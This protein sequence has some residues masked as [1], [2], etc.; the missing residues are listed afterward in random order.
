MMSTA[1]QSAVLERI[2]HRR[3]RSEASTLHQIA[4][5]GTK[6]SSCTRAA[7]HLEPG[8]HG[9]MTSITRPVTVDQQGLPPTRNCGTARAGGQPVQ[10][11]PATSTRPARG[12]AIPASAR[13][14][15]DLPLPLGPTTPTTYPAARSRATSVSMV[16]RPMAQ[17]SATASM[18]LTS[19]TGSGACPAAR[20]RPGR[21]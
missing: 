20:G 3:S 14:S 8:G 19:R 4:A 16:R 9:G 6:P 21:R 11:L 7:R 17:V 15:V 10:V 12:L 1:R 18:P 13:S 2:E 5:D